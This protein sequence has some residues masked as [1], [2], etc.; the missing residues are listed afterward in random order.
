MASVNRPSLAGGDWNGDGLGDLVIGGNTGTLRLIPSGGAFTADGTGAEFA[1]GSSRSLPALGDMDGDGDTDLIVLLDDGTA[2]FYA[3]SGYAMPYAAPG[4][5][6]FLGVAA[7]AATSIATGDLNRD[8]LLDVL[9]ADA[10]GRIWEFFR[11]SNG[12]FTLKSKVWGGS[13]A[14][15]ASG[16]TL[17]AV[18]LEG[19]GDLDMIAGLANG[20]LLTLRDPSVGRPTGLT[21]AAGANSIQLD[22]DPNWQSR[23]RGYYIYRALDAAGPWAKLVPDYVPLPSYLDTAVDPASEYF[24][25]VSGVSYF[26]LPGNSEP[27][28]VES[29]P[30]DPVS[31][32]AGHVTLSLRRVRG[33]PQQLRSG[34]RFRSRTHSG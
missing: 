5:D 25:Y 22:W 6:N 31:A 30:S 11:N 1:T 12:T 16:L 32:S 34:C 7:P 26:F 13:Y 24:Y 9:L 18:D 19:D 23:I 29:L 3:N 27:R 33:M 14:G 8:G 2:R 4:I 21:A 17:A 15:F 20:G 10:D 28:R